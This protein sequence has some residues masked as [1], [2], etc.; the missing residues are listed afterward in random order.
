MNLNRHNLN[1]KVVDVVKIYNFGVGFT[2]IRVYMKMLR[3]FEGMSPR[4]KSSNFR[5]EY[6]VDYLS[7]KIISNEKCMNYKVVALDEI[8]N[9]CITFISRTTK[10]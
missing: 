2:S 8:Y 4:E 6:S 7:I 1:Y 10:L 5:F 9:F 3:V